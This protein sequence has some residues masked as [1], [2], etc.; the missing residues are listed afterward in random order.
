MATEQILQRLMLKGRLRH[1]QMISVVARCGSMQKAARDLAVSQ[2]AI[3]KAVGE[4][5]TE[6]GA[7][8]FERHARGIRL[9][10][11]GR[12]VLPALERILAATAQFAE[13][14]DQYHS[15][16]A[17]VLRVA[18]V[19]AG[20]SGLL[21]RQAVAFCRANPDILLK[22]DEVDGPAILS[23]A[24][25][26]EYDLFLCR[27]PDTLPEGW[28]FLP[29][30]D[31]AHAIIAAPDHPLVGRHD[32]TLDDLHAHRWQKPPAGIPA[33][34]VLATLFQGRPP[35]VMAGIATRSR[36]LNRAVL[37]ELGLL[38]LAPVSIFRAELRTGVL[39]LVNYPLGGALRPLGVLRR[40]HAPGEAVE[41]FVAR[42]LKS[43]AKRA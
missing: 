36:A 4:L 41:R 10:R 37:L 39:A 40:D 18:S 35:P 43:G 16:G 6:L 32:V 13:A 9:T 23:L 33:D 15:Q 26:D 25:R 38:S 2:P 22:I 12:Q 34:E 7:A 1:V 8:L 14:V 28:H 20:I 24:A 42:L 11:F 29:V 27:R 5:E 30:I 19:A 3:T 31:D 21:D 17:T